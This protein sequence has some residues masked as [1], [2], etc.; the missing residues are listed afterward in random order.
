MTLISSV[1]IKEGSVEKSRPLGGRLFSTLRQ[2]MPSCVLRCSVPES[3]KL[4]ETVEILE[5]RH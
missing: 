2:V 1:K 3:E 4:R 5:E